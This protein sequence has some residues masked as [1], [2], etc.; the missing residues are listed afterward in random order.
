MKFR[1]S[2]VE[3]FKSV[4]SG[5]IHRLLKLLMVLLFIY[6]SVQV[7]RE[8]LNYYLYQKERLNISLRNF[9]WSFSI[10]KGELSLK[11][12]EFSVNSGKSS[13]SVD[14]G[15]VEVLV[16]DSLLNLRPHFKLI[17]AERVELILPSSENRKSSEFS[18]NIPPV[19]IDKLDIDYLYFKKG[20]FYLYG[21]QLLKDR[22]KVLIGGIFGKL[23]G[24]EFS[25]LP[26]EGYFDGGKLIIPTLDFSYGSLNL[27]GSLSF[28]QE[29]GKGEFV[30]SLVG[31]VFSLGKITV[32]INGKKFSADARGKV[33]ERKILFSGNGEYDLKDLKLIFSKASG[34]LDG[35]NFTLKGI[36]S[37][38][39]VS[40]RGKVDGNVKEESFILEGLKGDFSLKGKTKNP[41]LR[42]QLKS[43]TLST[44]FVELRGIKVKG[45]I[46]K[47]R[48]EVELESPKITGNL[49]YL[50]KKLRGNFNLKD[51]ELGT[52]KQV[53]S[54]KKKYGSWIPKVTL[55]GRLSFNYDEEFKYEGNLKVSSFYFR[56]FKGKGRAYIRGNSQKTLFKVLI[57]GNE[58][59]VQGRGEISLSKREI[60]S[61]FFGKDL[62]VSSID[63]LRKLGL[64]GRVSGSGRVF[65]K[66]KEPEAKFSFSSP[67]LSL[68]KVFI[69]NVEGSV[70]YKDYSLVVSAIS[71]IGVNLNNLTYLIREKKVLLDVNVE[72]FP[73]SSIL[74]IVEGFGV[75]LPFEVSGKTTSSAEV[76]I[77][78]SKPKESSVNLKVNSFYGSFTYQN[79]ISV[80]GNGS[81]NIIYRSKNLFGNFSGNL[82][83][84]VF[85]GFKFEEGKYRVA[86]KGRNLEVNYNGI[87]LYGELK[88]FKSSG[89]VDLLLDK[90]WINGKVRVFGNLVKP[91][92]SLG[93]DYLF[94]FSGE[95]SNFT[96]KISGK[97][98]LE[99]KYLEKP[100][101][102]EVAGTVNEPSNRGNIKVFGSGNE[103][104][105]ILFGERGNVVGKVRRLKIKDTKGY[106]LIN[107]GFVNLEFPSFSGY[108]S[109]PTFTVKPYGFYKLYS[110]TG[111]YLKISNKELEISPFTLS[112]VDGW[113]EI[114]EPKIEPISA[115]FKAELGVKGL[116]YL[117]KLNDLIKYSK[118][119]L[120][121]KGKFNYDKIL[122]YDA[123][124]KGS[125]I[126]LR[127]KYILS[128]VIVNDL[129][130][131]VSNG[132]VKVLKSEISVGDGNVLINKTNHSVIMALSQIPVGEIGFW[133]SLVSGNLTYEIKKKSL[134]GSVE[135]SKTKL[136]L[137]ERKEKEEENKEVRKIPVEVSIG[138][139][140]SEPVRLK[141]ELF[142]IEILPTLK[143]TTLNGE[144][145][146][147]GNFY[148]T[149]GE[150]NY[151]GKKFKVLYGSGTIEDLS[152]KR[153]RLSILASAHISGYYIY[154]KIEG[155]FSSPTI[156]L[157]SDPPLTREEILNLIMTGASPE[158]V[159]ASSE[160]FP[161]VQI[162]YYA[163]S[164]FFKPIES[165]FQ[166]ALG[167]ENFSIEPYITKYGETV[168]KLTVVKKLSERIRLVG[169]E[170][171]GQNPEYG[172]SLDFRLDDKYYLE[173]RYN[174]YYGAEAGIGAEV[175]IR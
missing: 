150:I 100:I 53:S 28:D 90:N 24:K 74:K 11:F 114:R 94:V 57:G 123:Y 89:S 58:G 32:K 33:K 125:D 40:L 121:V 64:K 166:E 95:V 8:L 41:V 37:P 174:S 136:F 75:K 59:K 167:L 20:N 7:G 107:L 128:K 23:G 116:I 175:R 113:I 82:E 156:Y 137:K 54:F 103:I 151:M 127:S 68:F 170:T 155:E 17:S 56:G 131:R 16:Y 109:V 93:G 165:K 39:K 55:N 157:S 168:A 129:T 164:S 154:M 47:E 106:I 140:F 26:L 96:V 4:K 138:A 70:M 115:K 10:K 171:T 126:S 51:F 91:V 158:Q 66:L 152:K 63:F 83:K 143:L 78:I 153:G 5:R 173:L 124:I 2:L 79:L 44:Q 31:D 101:E 120:K 160:L 147:S 141:G 108:V 130:G 92:G 22:E 132:E 117:F 71:P 30:G 142:W 162:A 98:K 27:K 6:L 15:K 105:V 118:G 110:P 61:R 67:E 36:V 149:D 18:L 12:K 87:N 62:E 139:L 135:L 86:F 13:L 97:G 34:K 38:E 65:G 169:Y 43:K 60:D 99:S 9:K 25:L 19:L 45:K 21:R 133:K 72:D 49:S 134:K 145:V 80:K 111:V 161:A 52:I 85:K 122:N 112:Y 163:A 104:Y 144:P 159:E 119:N 102:L 76:I 50:G 42:V 148:V 29:R 81:G 77:P 73:S 14:D 69:P 172:G 46:S 84:G 48:G 146:I 3:L 1:E 88:G 35:L